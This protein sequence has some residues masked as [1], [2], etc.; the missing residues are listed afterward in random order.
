VPAS[1][2]QRF[3]VRVPL[4]MSEYEFWLYERDRTRLWALTGKELARHA[5]PGDS[6]V[7]GAVGAIGYHS[8][9]FVYDRFGLVNREVARRAVSD[10]EMRDPWQPPGH[11]K[12]VPPEYFL[13]AR[14]TF[15]DAQILARPLDAEVPGYRTLFHLIPR[16][17]GSGKLR[18]LRLVQRSDLPARGGLEREEFQR[19]SQDTEG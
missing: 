13:P 14:P 17:R 10:A 9:V 16:E 1:L 8:R 12:G 4:E 11:L 15:L 3:R 2:R 5:E 18:I 6:L 19:L 7:S